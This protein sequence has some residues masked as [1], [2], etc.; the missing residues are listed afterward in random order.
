MDEESQFA[1]AMADVRPLKTV[2]RAETAAPAKSA[3]QSAARRRAAEAETAPDSNYLTDHC[4]AP[5]APFDII[6]FVRPGVQHGVYGKLRR[7]RYA[8]EASLD[9]HRM[10]V[11]QA[12]VEVWDFLQRASAEQLRTVMILH[13]KGDRSP[14]GAVLKSFVAEWLQQ[15]PE[16][17]AYHSA[18]P[19]Q[20]GAGAL[21][22]LL[23]KSEA[24]RERNRE[25]YRK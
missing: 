8:V 18:Q 6:G 15:L 24:A 7:G 12:R 14:R 9:L 20:G 16:V 21:Y 25:R 13:G 5:V 22:V 11:A 10:T 23:K 1:H 3:L 19:A 2:A 4:R 17:L